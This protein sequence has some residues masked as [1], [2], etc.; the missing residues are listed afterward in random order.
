MNGA[1]FPVLVFAALALV[2]AACAWLAFARGRVRWAQARLVL[3]T[4]TS[5]VRN[6]RDGFVE[7]EG[8]AR[9]DGDLV[10]SPLSGRR[11]VYVEILVEEHV[12]R[13]KSSYW[14]TVVDDVRTNGLVLDDGSGRA[15]IEVSEA[16]RHFEVDER[17][18]SGF[19]N[20]APPEVEAALQQ[21]YGTSSVGLVFNKSMRYR[22]TVI[23]DGD[24][25]YVI[26]TA[27]REGGGWRIG[28]GDAGPHALFVVSDRGERASY[29]KVRLGAIG[30]FAVTGVFAALGAA[31][32][33]LAWAAWAG[34][35]G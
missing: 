11:G 21:H 23:A 3:D 32:G 2:C 24:P 20:D 12:R 7:L 10:S 18:R 1:S 27:R 35:L 33:G 16:E 15:R 13:R 26:G 31:M 34:H 8:K 14:R 19:L 4:P 22:E 6:L 30:R 9:T 5:R 29:E 17:S 28:C 25:L